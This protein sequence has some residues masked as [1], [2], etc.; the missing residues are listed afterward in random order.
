MSEADI[1]AARLVDW[2]DSA[3]L[4]GGLSRRGPAICPA[5]PGN[6]YKPSDLAMITFITSLVPA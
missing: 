6:A 1:D 5:A 2:M 4:S 3:A